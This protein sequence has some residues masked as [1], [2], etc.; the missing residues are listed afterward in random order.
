MNEHSHLPP[1]LWQRDKSLRRAA[2]LIECSAGR[3]RAVSFDFFDTLVW[4]LV[5]R[6]VDAFHE[7]GHRLRQKQLLRPTISAADFEML[8]QVAEM[9]TRERQAIKDA[10]CED[11][12]ILDIYRQMGAILNDPAAGVEVEHGAESD[13][14]LLN[15][16]MAGFI[17]HV[18]QRGL[19]VLII[20]DIYFSGD[21]LRGILRANQFNPEIFDSVLTSSD[22]GAC[23]GTGNLFRHAL[24]MLKLE[25]GQLLH[26]GDNFGADVVGA[27]RA[28]VRGCHYRQANSEITTILDR[29]KFLLG[30]QA[31]SFSFNSLRQLA[32][33]NFDGPSDEEFFGRSGALLLGPLLTRYATWACEQFAAAGVRKVGAFM[34][35][36]EI[37]GRLL[38]NEA[39]AMGHALEITSLYVNRKSTDLAAIDK[40]SAE[41]IIGWLERRQTLSVKTILEHFGLLPAD[42]ENSPFSPGEKI[43]THERILKLAKFLFTP[44]IAG[45]IEAR[46]AEERRKVMD[47]LRPWIESGAPVGLCDLGYNASAQTQLKRI[48]DIEGHAARFIGCYL[49]TCE[50][51]ASRVLDGMDIRHFLGAF[52]QPDFNHFAFLRSPAFV[53]QC[54]VAQSGTTLGYERAADG[55][56]KPV[57]D[58]MRFPPEL[59]RRQRGFKDGVLFFQKLWLWFRAQKP[60][61]LGGSSENSRRILAGLDRS[62]API[63]ARATAFPLPCEQLHFGS[64]PLDDYYF[65]E[66]VKTIC[67]P[68]ERELARTGGYANL[69]T[70]QGVLWPQAVFHLE[71]PRVASDFFSCGKA[72][73]LC[74]PSGDDNGAQPELTVIIPPQRD[75][76]SLRECLNRLKPVYSR[77][78][79]VVL[80]AAKDDKETVAVA[81]E[82]S[83]EIKRLRILERQPL[84][85]CNQQLNFAVD[86]SAAAFA[87]FI[88]G[89]TPLS[90]GWDAAMLNAIRQAPDVAIVFPSLRQPGAKPEKLALENSLDAVTRCF[91]VRRSAFI[92]GLGFDEKLGRT[93]TTLNLIFQM[94]DLGWKS[95]SCREAVA[96]IKA[97]STSR[98]PAADAKFLKSRWPDFAKKVAAIFPEPSANVPTVG[99]NTTVVNWIGSFLDHGSLSQVNREL[100][101]ELKKFSGIEIRRIG[102]SAPASPDFEKLSRDL[103]SAASPEAVVTVRHAWPPDWK[104]PQNGK[105]AVIQPWEFGA[106]PEAWVR[107]SRDVDEFWVPSNY[108]R[109]CYVASGVPAGKVFVV[110]NGVDAEKFHPQAAPM[111]LATQKKF[112]FLFVGGTIA[113]KGPDLLLKACLQNFTAAD[114]VCLVIK[115]FGGKSVYAGQTFESQIRA[116]QSQPDAPEILFLNQELPPDALPGLYAACNCLVLPYR[117]EGFGLPVVEAMACGLPVIVTAGGATD[118][119]VRDEFAW[120]IPAV[121][122]IFG[123]E[124]SGMKLAGPGWLL[125]PDLAAL[126]EL[127]R[128]AFS[129]PD[130]ARER[131]HRAGRHARQFCSWKNSAALVAQRIQELAG[132]TST[133]PKIVAEAAPVQLPSVARIGQLDEAREQ[134]GRK[135]FEAAWTSALAAVAKRPFHPEAY[136]LLAEIALAAG[137]GQIAK[138][139]AQ[140]SRDL[141]PN[142]KAPRQFL[143]KTLNGTARFEWL[144]LPDQIGN[145]KSEI[146]NK[147]SVCLIVKNEEKFLAQCLASIKAIASQIIVVDTGSTDRTME[148][149]KEFGA[150]IYS[151]AWC[152]DFSAARNVA[153]EHAVG[154]WILM[155]DADEELPADQHARLLADMKH[156]DAI[157]SRLPLVDNGEEARGKY[158]VPRLFRN[159][160]GIYYYSRIHEQVFPSLVECG[161]KW[162]LITAVGTAQLLHHGYAKEIV[163][164]RNKVERNLHLLRLAVQEFPG[165]PN[166]QMNL[167]LELVR[168]G[169]LPT[170]LSH[171]REAFRLMSAQPPAGIVPELREVLLTQFTRHLHK[172]RA[173]D[174]IVQTLNSPLAKNGGLTASLH[175]ALGLAHFEL[176]QF[177]EAADQMRQCLARRKQTA[178]SPINPDI[179]T[180]VPNHCLAMSLLKLG[181][182]AG[183]EKA[184]Q[185]GLAENGRTEELKLDYAKFL[186]MQN[187][188]VDALKKL[189]ELVHSNANDFV[190]WRLGGEIA[191]SKPEFLEFARDWTGEAVRQLPEDNVLVAQRAE[192]LLL[193]QEMVAA[194]PLWNRAVNGER[195]PRAL[196][197]QIICATIAS[198]PVEKLQGD[199]EEAA[200]SRAFVDW[201]RR[202]VK[203]GARDTIIGLNSRVETLR[204]ILPAAAGVLDGVV[205]ETRKGA[206][207]EVSAH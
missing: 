46:S 179:L 60:G 23:K 62:C 67:G 9:K 191:L 85:T 198:Q 131:G 134:F 165:E 204:P 137:D 42:V 27:R 83:R 152:N 106:L 88:D 105:L 181:D 71:S 190:A 87:V 13:L 133:S 206:M 34:R 26:I 138:L 12:R 56:V 188:P 112:K 45:Q 166:L 25:A 207:A 197:A 100:T 77:A 57:L 196:A 173:H 144:V 92:E 120:R 130:E 164:D 163:R 2:E 160:P 93:A 167:G 95:A 139:C 172:A 157:A 150:E 6:P 171:Y 16:V 96:E 32:A 74:N 182:A 146:G 117:G 44:K 63:L 28:G 31:P 18:R 178:L 151:F 103:S 99:A 186:A 66:G 124:V 52:G 193:S 91:L 81:K 200:V 4:R 140:R 176:K 127:M 64:L 58:E 50:R 35:E 55:T 161:K 174:E 156:A 94:H 38:Q 78:C 143:K 116:A 175:L 145:R 192:V 30:G 122:K 194:L 162:G 75:A 118:D 8:R 201:Y 148:I 24:K 97:A 89:N 183:A 203:A 114:D 119:F 159:A 177:S 19:R 142:W 108:V 132:N 3:V 202:L 80:L 68:Q 153:L 59:L 187:R 21:H 48:L 82:F 185:A 110:P 20:S 135:N 184:Y 51:A 98:L 47:Y 115:D 86:S 29:E 36:G 40:L 170:G 90:P 104:R 129:K 10:T 126:G 199:S 72:M 49:V 54:L 107:Q 141:A 158:F 17:Q 15:P 154:D 65:A 102:N 168:S 14:C 128:R 43:N 69:L 33:R 111:Q 195:P 84:Q 121:K 41:S 149:A 113:R 147:L 1:D 205:A 180:A 61:L 155:L 37:L 189:N 11:I 73:L 79:E 169:D 5:A 70:R 39:D 123:H 109:D 101:G 7:A 136:L 125:E 22:T 53:E 76:G